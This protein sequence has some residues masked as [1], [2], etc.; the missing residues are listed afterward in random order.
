MQYNVTLNGA[1]RGRIEDAESGPAPAQTSGRL[2]RRSAQV[3]S[4]NVRIGRG[5]SGETQFILPIPNGPFVRFP[6]ICS[7]RSNTLNKVRSIFVLS[8][9]TNHRSQRHHF[10][11]AVKGRHKRD[12]IANLVLVAADTLEVIRVVVTANVHTKAHTWCNNTKQK[13]SNTE[14][15]GNGTHDL[16][17]L[18]SVGSIMMKVTEVSKRNVTDV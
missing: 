13:V 9:H 11:R 10:H 17:V 18:S 8:Q 12:A 2:Q 1:L 7:V 3:Q 4:R 16:P 14:L 5:Y 15:G 6:N